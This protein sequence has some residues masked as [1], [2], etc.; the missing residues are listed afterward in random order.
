MF[1]IR[2][3]NPQILTPYATYGIVL[4]NVAAWV[5]LQGLGSEPSLSG[6]VC[7]FGLIPG[8][9]LQ[10]VPA[11]SRPKRREKTAVTAI[12]PD[13][14]I[15]KTHLGK[16]PTHFSEDSDFGIASGP[17]SK[18]VVVQGK[19]PGREGRPGSPRLDEPS[20]EAFPSENTALKD[21][22]YAVDLVD[23]VI[24]DVRPVVP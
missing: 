11:G 13:A 4:I 21:R 1:P 2:D 22:T 18:G 16:G 15:K 17:F 14:Q 19:I 7:Q 6:S 10:L 20:S 23:E 3:D 24:L 12:A 5:F 9:L 8:E